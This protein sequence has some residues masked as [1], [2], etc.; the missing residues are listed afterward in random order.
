MNNRPV[1]NEG[2]NPGANSSDKVQ[3]GLLLRSTSNGVQTQFFG[4]DRDSSVRR[5]RSAP[6]S[7]LNPLV[8]QVA[9]GRNEDQMQYHREDGHDLGSSDEDECVNLFPPDHNA[10]S[11][12]HKRFVVCEGG[13]GLKFAEDESEPPL[14]KGPLTGLPEVPEVPEVPKV[15]IQYHREDENDLGSSDEDEEIEWED[16]DEWE[17][18]DAPYFDQQRYRESGPRRPII[19]SNPFV[20]R[21]RC[22][23]EYNLF[24]DPNFENRFRRDGPRSEL[25]S[26]I[27]FSKS[28]LEK[29]LKRPRCDV[30]D[31]ND[32]SV[33]EIC[34]PTY[35]LSSGEKVDVPIDWFERIE[36]N[37]LQSI[38]EDALWI[39]D[40]ED[41]DYVRHKCRSH[42]LYERSEEFTSFIN[43]CWRILIDKFNIFHETRYLDTISLMKKEMSHNSRCMLSFYSEQSS[44]I[45]G[46]DGDPAGVYLILQGL[47]ARVRYDEHFQIHDAVRIMTLFNVGAW[48]EIL[49][50]F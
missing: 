22:E 20:K 47:C 28:Q 12:L 42:Y 29:I 16:G 1:N 38:V 4:N 18:D 34:D 19:I 31:G 11:M 7:M 14:K 24:D 30:D 43:D 41:L 35:T 2:S 36:S 44:R 23:D 40:Q 33:E 50:G 32:G 21:K 27:D 13:L 9:H 3:S 17:D 39:L 10:Y 8:R 48:R 15:T 49:E 6:L 45:F 26:I 5:S 25:S 46:E 37:D